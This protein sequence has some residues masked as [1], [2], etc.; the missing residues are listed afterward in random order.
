MTHLPDAPVNPFRR[1][2]I[3]RQG[4]PV[5]APLGTTIAAAAATLRPS[6]IAKVYLPNAT[7]AKVNLK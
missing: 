6:S 3:L 1:A 4:P 7:V 5:Y 2:V